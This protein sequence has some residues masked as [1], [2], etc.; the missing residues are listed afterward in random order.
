MAFSKGNGPLYL[1]V[2]M[3]FAVILFSALS[4]E[5]PDVKELDSREFQQ[6]VEE[7]A[8]ALDPEEDRPATRGENQRA[9][10][11]RGLAQPTGSSSSS[12]AGGP[13][14]KPG[15]LT[16]YD[17]SQKVTGLL[18]AEGGASYKSSST[19]TPRTTT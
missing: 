12:A 1:F 19:P 18:K 4:A 13:E 7:R 11:P 14:L 8:F 10:G 15:P 5:D 9:A 2:L 3:V 16:I 17:E 6:A